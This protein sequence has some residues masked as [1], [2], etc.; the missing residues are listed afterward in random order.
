MRNGNFIK[1]E[2]AFTS[3]VFSSYPTYEE[4]KLFSFAPKLERLRGSY[5]T[6]EEWKLF[7]K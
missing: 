7:K 3:F 1:E 5:P 4:W 2:E 6:Y